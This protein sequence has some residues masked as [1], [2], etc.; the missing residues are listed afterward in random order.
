MNL[1]CIDSWGEASSSHQAQ[2]QSG[3]EW[4]DE[5]SWDGYAGDENEAMSLQELQT[6]LLE[7][8]YV[9]A[10]TT[11][12]HHHHRS[13]ERH[14]ADLELQDAGTSRQRFSELPSMRLLEHLHLLLMFT[15]LLVNA[16]KGELHVV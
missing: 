9:A 6:S 14:E 7:A 3:A 12:H 13:E 1:A 10:G 8:G 5:N 11:R 2:E 16:L 15:N 4:W